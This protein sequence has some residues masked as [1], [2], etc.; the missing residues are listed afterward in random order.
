M[1]NVL[2][3]EVL[4]VDSVTRSGSLWNE[5]ICNNLLLQ[6]YFSFFKFDISALSELKIH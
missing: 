3:L 6:T 2:G 1:A 5:N 4:D